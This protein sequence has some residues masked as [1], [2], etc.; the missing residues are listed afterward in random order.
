MTGDFAGAKIV[1]IERLTVNVF[2]DQ[3]T[4]IN[5]QQLMDDMDK[6]SPDMQEILRRRLNRQPQ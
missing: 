2:H 5:M 4:Q 6:L 1:N 3:S